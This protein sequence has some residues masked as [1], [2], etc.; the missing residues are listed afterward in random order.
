MRYCLYIQDYEVF[1]CLYIQR[2][3]SALLPVY[4]KIMGYATACIYKD[5]RECYCLCMYKDYGECYLLPV[6]TKIMVSATACVYTKIPR[7]LPTACIYK[8][9]VVRY[10][11]YI[12]RLRSALLP[13]YTKIREC[14]TA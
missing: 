2:L 9:S 6:Y 13:E 1:Y 11:L 12:Q 14:A 8:D 4:E 7:V 3:Q 5:Y 10:C